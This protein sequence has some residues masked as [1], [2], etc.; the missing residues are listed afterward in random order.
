VSVEEEGEVDGDKILV[1]GF[2]TVVELLLL[3]LLGENLQVA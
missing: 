1:E 2:G 3:L